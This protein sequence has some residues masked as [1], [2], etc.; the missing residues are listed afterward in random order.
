M[1]QAIF[2]IIGLVVGAL[3]GYLI[4]RL[5]SKQGP[6]G[7]ELNNALVEKNTLSG[8]LELLEQEKI[9]QEKFLRDQVEKTE[10][11]LSGERSKNVEAEKKIAQL[12]AMY[13]SL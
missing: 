13:R 10:T 3:L 9:R 2:L 11:E 1:Q 4:A 6:K 12:S 5:M 7:A 8:K